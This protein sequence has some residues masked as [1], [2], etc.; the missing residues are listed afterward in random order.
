M[1]SKTFS[2]R[3]LNFLI[4]E[5]FNAEELTQHPYFQDYNREAFDMVLDTA[6]DIADK[7]LYPAFT[8]ADRTPPELVNGVVKVHPAVGRFLKATG[9]AGLIGAGFSFEHGGQQLPEL[10]SASAGFI[11][12][13]ANNALIMFRGLSEGSAHL[14]MSF[15]SPE[16]NETYVPN[17]LNGKWS[18][19]MCLT[20][21]QAGSALA[22]ITTTATPQPNGSYKIRGQ[23]VFISAGEHDQTENIIHLVLARIDGAPKGTK[24]ISLLVVPKKRLTADGG[25]EDNDVTPTGLYHKMGQKGTPAMHLTFGEKDNSI[26]YLLGEPH[27]GLSYMFQMMNEA[28][29]GVGM[30]GAYIASAAYYASLQYANERPQGRRLNNKNPDEPPTLIINHPDVRRMLLFQK[31]VVEGSLGLILQATKYYDLMNVTEGEERDN[32]EALLDLL[33]PV[34]KTFPSEM[35]IRAVSEGMQVLGGYGYTEDFP[36]EQYYRDIRITSI[37][38]GTTTIQSLD[39]LARKVVQRGGKGMQL[40]GREIAQVVAEARTFDDLK[41]YADQ[42]TQ[43]LG[44][45]QTVTQHLLGIMATGDAE[46][47]CMDATLYMEQFGLVTVGWQWL[48]QAVVAKQALIAQAPTGDEA[49]FYEAKVHTMKYFFHYEL[50]KSLYLATRLLDTEAITLPT[51]SVVMQ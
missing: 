45:V 3:N 17:M 11:L 28:R 46:R 18:G 27:K 43:E 12:G 49:A 10:V 47:A 32:Y 41:P 29:L 30:C 24:G 25:L 5:V 14:I 9:E 33:T 37:Y 7:I 40:L 13:A 39:L 19:T 1:A 15:G 4:H 22:D 26:G 36:L 21:P 6:T 51:E 35:G 44:R 23:K 16:L 2:R 34:A 8:E 48:K 42:L 31:A 50:P 38:E 20:E